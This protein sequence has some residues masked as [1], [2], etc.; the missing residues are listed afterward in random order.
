MYAVG[1]QGGDCIHHLLN[2]QCLVCVG[3]RM[4]ELMSEG[5]IK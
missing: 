4:V 5:G 1:P 3:M 2:V